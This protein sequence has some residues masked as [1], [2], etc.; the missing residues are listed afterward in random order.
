MR[1][2]QAL[3]GK[4]QSMLA[5]RRRDAEFRREGQ[6]RPVAPWRDVSGVDGRR[7][8]G[9]NV[10]RPRAPAARIYGVDAP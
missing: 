3:I 7:G 6:I 1:A 2:R 5:R 10:A 8:A 4:F 9:H